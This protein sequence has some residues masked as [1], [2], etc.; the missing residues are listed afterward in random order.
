MTTKP[1][2]LICGDIVWAHEQVRSLLGPIAEV[3]RMDSS[4]REEFCKELEA[5]GKFSGTVAIYRHNSSADRIGIFD[6]DLVEHLPSSV[7][8]IAHNGAGYDQI[9][10][11]ACK[12]K[13][14]KV[15]N[16]PG[17]VDDATATTALY[18]LISVT[19]LYCLGERVVRDTSKTAS[20][21]PGWKPSGISNSAHDP[22]ALVL[23]ILGMGGIGLRLAYLCRAF[24]PP[25]RVLYYSRSV[26]PDMPDWAEYVQSQDELL[27]R[28]DVL[29]VHVPLRDDT[30]GLIGEKEIR[31]LRKGSYIV[32][33]AR[34]KIID[35]EALIGAL[36][37]GHLAGA[38]LDVYPNEPNINPK[39]LTFSN[40][41]L[42]PHMGT[43][44][45]EAQCKME[46][47]ALTNIKD[48]LEKGVGRDLIVEYQ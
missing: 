27:E 10:V 45:R 40:V 37:D 31:K 36:E 19:R 17:A 47:R 38:G 9:D 5:D 1:R 26:K 46:V 33:T 2:V 29:S 30:V 22:S 24:D 21:S 48:F 34:G 41:A 8:W 13:G 20:G 35:E 11:D 18:L 3:V 16:T 43:E 44:T 4:S 25:M 42:L 39:L 7:K 6:K 28:S 14:I 15:S 12:S 32:N 23:G